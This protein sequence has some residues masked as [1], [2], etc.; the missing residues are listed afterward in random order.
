MKK[1]DIIKW[2]KYKIG[3]LFQIESAKGKNSQQLNDGNDVAYIAASKECNG[4]NRMVS[5]EGFENWVSKGNCIQL[6][7]IGDAAAGY[8]NYIPDN[9]IAMS[10]KSSCAYN[11]NMTR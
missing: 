10:G 6:I 9:F 11:R 4:F 8:A 3:D 7:H 5:I 1:I 2:R